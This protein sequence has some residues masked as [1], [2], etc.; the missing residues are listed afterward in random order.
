MMVD[1]R[2]AGGSIC[3][4]IETICKKAAQQIFILFAI[5]IDTYLIPLTWMVSGCNLNM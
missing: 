1:E 4:R 5:N 2:M 3:T